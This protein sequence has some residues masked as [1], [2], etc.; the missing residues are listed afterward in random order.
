MDQA[1]TTPPRLLLPARYIL[2]NNHFLQNYLANFFS[3]LVLLF[4]HSFLRR[5]ITADR[6]KTSTAAAAST[7]SPWQSPRSGAHPSRIHHVDCALFIDYSV[8]STTSSQ[9]PQEYIDRVRHTSCFHISSIVADKKVTSI[10]SSSSTIPARR[11]A[12]TS[13]MPARRCTPTSTVS[14]ARPTS[15]STPPHPIKSQVFLFR[16]LIIIYFRYTRILGGCIVTSLQF[17]QHMGLRHYIVTTNTLD[18]S[19]NL[20]SS[21]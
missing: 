6:N 19:I 13:T 15:T 3:R 1:L 12:T 20:F 21:A 2:P 7:R 4:A 9:A 8:T 18:Y 17:T 16:E 11:R 14:A 5:S 10:A